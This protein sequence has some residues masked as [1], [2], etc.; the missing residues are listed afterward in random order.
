MLLSAGTIVGCFLLPW[1]AERFGRRG[2]LAWYFILMFASVAVGFGYV[3]Y[4]ERDALAWF[5][6]IMFILGV[7]GASFS[8][9]TLWLPEQYRS[10]CR[11][12]AFAFATSSGRF[13]TAGVT[14]LVGAAVAGMGTIGTPVA[15]TSLAFLVGLALL[16]LAEETKGKELPA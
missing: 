1:L 12:S 4:L 14:F 7:G 2:A 10:E 16:P 8:V 3:Y 13:V 15:L 5:M 6:T 11:G 9:F